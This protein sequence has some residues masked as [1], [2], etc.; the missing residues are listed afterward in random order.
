MFSFLSFNFVA[1]KYNKTNLKYFKIP[2]LFR[3]EYLF[4]K[5]SISEFKSVVTYI[6]YFVFIC[7]KHSLPSPPPPS[8]FSSIVV[9]MSPRSVKAHFLRHI[10][11]LLWLICLS[12]LIISDLVYEKMF[13]SFPFVKPPPPPSPRARAFTE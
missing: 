7:N 4:S 5:E 12:K 11:L 3:I 6:I 1:A 13:G 10:W 8:K 9:K 2:L